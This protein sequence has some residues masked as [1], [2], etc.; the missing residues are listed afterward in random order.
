ME[1]QDLVVNWVWYL[2][3]NQQGL[4]DV[5][6][7]INNTAH[8]HS[9]LKGTMRPDLTK[10]FQSRASKCLPKAFIKLV[11]KTSQPFIQVVTDSITDNSTF[12]NGKL[13]L[14]CDAVVGAR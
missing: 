10:S 14:V 8:R 3:Q 11:H 5:M 13:L 2:I 9:L 4:D 1:E 12:L 6:R 7:D